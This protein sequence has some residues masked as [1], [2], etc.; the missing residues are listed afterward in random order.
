MCAML[1]I[2]FCKFFFAIKLEKV[3]VQPKGWRSSEDTLQQKEQLA[4]VM[5]V[6]AGRVAFYSS[7][8]CS[9]SISGSSNNC[10]GGV[11][12]DCIGKK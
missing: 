5:V 11:G 1:M 10:D 7:S 9:S 8:S 4:V 3:G 2:C 12:D 6:V